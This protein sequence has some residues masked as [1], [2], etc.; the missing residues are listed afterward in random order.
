MIWGLRK[1][2][3]NMKTKEEEQ[4]SIESL[5]KAS[6]VAQLLNIS[7][8]MVYKLMDMGY[9]PTIRI[10]SIVRVRQCDLDEFIQRGWSG[11]KS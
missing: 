11:W 5:Y 4:T 9:L 10:G 1:D 7:R 3:C 8:S 6:Q 2:R